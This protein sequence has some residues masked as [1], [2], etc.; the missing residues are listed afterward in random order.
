[1]HVSHLE[2][3][4]ISAQQNELSGGEK[5][6]LSIIRAILKNCPILLLDEADNHLDAQSKEWLS[7]FICRTDRTVIFI[8]H[9]K[10]FQRIM[11]KKISLNKG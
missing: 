9:E 5:Q 4:E 1:M 7:D 6:K 11:G 10:G 2:N 8:S 3:R